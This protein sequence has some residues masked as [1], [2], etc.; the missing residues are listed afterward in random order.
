MTDV[1]T[2]SAETL[3]A[4]LSGDEPF[5]ASIGRSLSGQPCPE[6]VSRETGC[7]EPSLRDSPLDDEIDRSPAEPLSNVP[8]SR[9]RTKERAFRELGRFNPSDES[10]DGA[11][12]RVTLVGNALFQALT[13]LIRL[14]PPQQNPQPFPL[15]PNVLHV[16]ADDFGATEGPAE[17]EQE[18]SPIPQAS[19]AC[20]E[21]GQHPA[22]LIGG[23]RR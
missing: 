7:I 16:E 14:A 6:A 1:P 22:K 15:L 17:R 3:P 2:E 8:M 18:Q 10:T 9:D 19:G 13:L 4:A 23:N 21:R 5:G 11:D 12:L 20:G